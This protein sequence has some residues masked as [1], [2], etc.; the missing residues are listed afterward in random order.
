MR[1][2]SFRMPAFL[3]KIAAHLMVLG[4]PRDRNGTVEQY[5]CLM[6]LARKR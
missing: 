6:I 1:K 3:A 2:G 4:L 5:A